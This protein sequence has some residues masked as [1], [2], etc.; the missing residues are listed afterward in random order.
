MTDKPKIEAGQRWVTRGGQTVR[1]VA[2]DCGEEF[3]IMGY[4]QDTHQADFYD[5]DG[6]SE[7]TTR[8][9][10][11]DFDLISL[12]PSTVKR[13]VALYRDETREGYLT[14]MLPQELALGGNWRRVSEV[15][16]VEFT[17]LPGERP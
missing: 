3:P 12:A 16:E 2:T 11:N 8:P 17:L 9:E 1:I 5:F 15:T 10:F 6:T 13:E 7:S 4:L 14:L